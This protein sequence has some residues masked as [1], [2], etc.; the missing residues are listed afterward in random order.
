MQATTSIKVGKVTV[1]LADGDR[2]VG[3]IKQGKE[4][5]PDTLSAFADAVRPGSTVLDIGCY[6]GLFAIAACKLGARAYGF[7]PMSEMRDRI[8]LNQEIN[9]VMFDVFEGAAAENDGTAD[10]GWNPNVKFTAGAS[11]ARKTGPHRRVMTTRVDSLA[12]EDVSVMKIDVE[13]H[14][15]AVIRGARDMITRCRPFLI[16]EALDDALKSAVLKELP[17]YDLVDVTD[18]RNLL[19]APRSVST[20]QGD[21]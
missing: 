10:I 6:S 12:F 4:F 8:R 18:V 17:D 13:R 14:E 20:R 11:F 7:E 19:L 9:H 21:R 15:A 5:E 1:E 16:V 2:I 3:H